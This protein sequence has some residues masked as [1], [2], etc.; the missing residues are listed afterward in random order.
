MTIEQAIR[1]RASAFYVSVL[2]LFG[3]DLARRRAWSNP[4]PVDLYQAV[5]DEKT[6]SVGCPSCCYDKSRI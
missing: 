1:Y 6:G 5:H 4:L 2:P 3:R